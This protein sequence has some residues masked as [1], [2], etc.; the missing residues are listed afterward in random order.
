LSDSHRAGHDCFADAAGSPDDATALAGAD[1]KR[2]AQLLAHAKKDAAQVFSDACES[3]MRRLVHAGNRR[4]WEAALHADVF[5]DDAELADIADALARGIATADLM[6]RARV[7]RRADLAEKRASSGENYSKNY[8]AAFAELS[9]FSPRP[10]DDDPF[11]DFAEPVPP[12]APESAVAYFQRLVP[13]LDGSTVRYGPR[14]DRHAFTLAAASDQVVLDRV[15]AAILKSL[16]EG[17]T[18]TPQVQDVL[19]SAGVSPRNPQYAEMVA[20]TNLQDAYNQGAQDELD[21][22]EMKEAFPAFEYLGILDSRTGEDHRPKIGKYYP[23]TASFA[24][25]RGPRVW[26]CRCTFAPI[27]KHLMQGVRVESNW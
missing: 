3:A 14:L 18:A 24:E 1:G 11:H 27:S 5:F 26:N 19:D 12:M 15:K 8:S 4:G 2:A 16:Q 22:P 23:S 13:T 6:G 7:R 10:D 9:A 21:S 25:V 17:P 20:R